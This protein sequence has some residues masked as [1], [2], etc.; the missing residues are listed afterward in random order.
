MKQAI[1]PG[2][3]WTDTK[4]ERI[5]A[6][7]GSVLYH[8]GFYYWYGENKEYSERESEIWHWGVRLYRSADLYNWEDLGLIV[9]PDT[10]DT[11]SPFHPKSHMDR[12]HILYNERTGR[13]VLWV[14]IMERD[15]RQTLSILT[16]EAITGPYELVKREFMPFGMSAGDFDLVKT[17]NGAVIFFEHPHTEMISAR[18]TEDYLDVAEEYHVHFPSQCPPLTREA[19]SHFMRNGKHYLITSGTSGKFPNPS[20]VAVSDTV[21]GPY[22]RVCDPHRGDTSCTSFHSQVSCVFKVEG[23]KDLYIAMADRW[24]PQQMDLRYEDYGRILHDMFS[25]EVSKEVRAR[26]YEEVEKLPPANTSIADYVWLPL[27]F[28]EDHVYLDWRDSWKVED[29]E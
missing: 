27:V 15:H 14:K 28:E 13:F 26:A 3:V 24:R 11:T 22:Q 5:Q 8:Q 1:Y 6:H 29:F 19:P 4:G 10:D 16:S 9:P 20:E 25:D 21:D 18:L 12:P 2:K 23:K 17:E 7:G